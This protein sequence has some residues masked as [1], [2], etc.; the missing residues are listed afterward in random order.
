MS[1]SLPKRKDNFFLFR[2]LWIPTGIKHSRHLMFLNEFTGG[3]KDGWVDVPR[4]KEMLLCD[5]VAKSHTYRPQ[6][7]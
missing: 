2:Q 1:L 5:G 7:S 3:L 6:P 4:N